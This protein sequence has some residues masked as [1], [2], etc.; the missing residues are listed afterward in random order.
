[1]YGLPWSIANVCLYSFC[2][3]FLFSSGTGGIAFGER[4][5]G[6]T[7]M[8][9]YEMMLYFQGSACSYSIYQVKSYERAI[10]AQKVSRIALEIH[11]RKLL[12][13]A[14]EKKRVQLE[15]KNLKKE[16][17]AEKKAQNDKLKKERRSS[18]SSSR[19]LSFFGGG[20]LLHSGKKKKAQDELSQHN[21]LTWT[22]TPEKS[23]KNRLWKL[24]N[25]VNLMNGKMTSVV[26]MAQEQLKKNVNLKYRVEQLVKRVAA[27]RAEYNTAEDNDDPTTDQL[28][29]TFQHL[30]QELVQ[31]KQKQQEYSE[32]QE[33][34]A[35]Q[36]EKIA[37]AREEYNTAEDND[38]PTTTQ[39]HQ[40]FQ[41]LKEEMVQLK[42]DLDME[43]AGTT[44]VAEDAMFLEEFE[45]KEDNEENKTVTKDSD[46]GGTRRNNDDDDDDDD[47]K[48][49]DVVDIGSSSEEEGEAVVK[50]EHKEEQEELP[51]WVKLYDSSHV[52]YYY[53]ENYTSETRWDRPTDYE[54]PRRDAK[55]SIMNLLNKDV[56]A[57]L[58]V[59][60]IYRAKQ[61]KRITNMARKTNL[62][63]SDYS[64][65]DWTVM[66]S[67]G[68]EYY[69][70]NETGEAVWELP[71]V[72]EWEGHGAEG[73]H[74]TQN[75]GNDEQHGAFDMNTW[76]LS[77]ADVVQRRSN[78]PKVV[79]QHKPTASK[80]AVVASNG[81]IVV[82]THPVIA[83]RNSMQVKRPDGSTTQVKKPG[84]ARRKSIQVKRPD[85]SW[86]EV[87]S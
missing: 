6:Q 57:A 85:G 40:K 84:I 11:V 10:Q 45:F 1:M 53:H 62:G 12:I 73:G 7:R 58:M 59:Q 25:K 69:V 74:H 65:G 68:T 18:K 86:I 13:E 4:H 46:G 33:N 20:S 48:G 31:L 15:L 81:S 67:H 21:I 8:Y 41:N 64:I 70:H 50:E 78:V 83:R 27:A 39:L 35:A 36:K 56:K 30:K 34:I 71:D 22:S 32:K 16:K 24:K 9:T 5:E 44:S 43:T 29:Q 17:K 76:E 47:D 52:A 26:D 14:E 87:P 23:K 75:G 49:E 28:H 19:R 60:K 63:L 77:P 54:S 79:Y 55:Y 61:A 82:P 2:I 38:D 66:D 37:K 42:L 72:D 80:Y 3:L 51:R